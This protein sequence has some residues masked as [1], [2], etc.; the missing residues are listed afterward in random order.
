MIATPLK[1]LL[2]THPET[3]ISLT[4]RMLFFLVIPSP[5]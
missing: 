4:D 1:F 5:E 2:R 3:S